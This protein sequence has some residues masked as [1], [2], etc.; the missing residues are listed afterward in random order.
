MLSKKYHSPKCQIVCLKYLIH[1]GFTFQRQ[2]KNYDPLLTD[3]ESE[4]QKATCSRLC[5][6]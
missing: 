6:A 2:R 3:E 4:T 5:D 1:A